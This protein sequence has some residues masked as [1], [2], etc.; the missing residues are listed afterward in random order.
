MAAAY[1]ALTNLHGALYVTLAVIAL[2]P[3]GKVPLNFS[4]APTLLDGTLGAFLVVYL[5]QWMTGQ[6]RLFRS[7]PVTPVVIGFYRDHVLRLPD[8]SALCARWIRA[9]CAPSRR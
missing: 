9:R 1:Y 6:R 3:F 4:P 7:T 8:G 2:I 5:F